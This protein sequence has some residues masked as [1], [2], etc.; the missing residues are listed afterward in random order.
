MRRKFPFWLGLPAV[1]GAC[2]SDSTTP[3]AGP[4]KVTLSITKLWPK[5]SQTWCP[6]GSPESCDAQAPEPVVIGC[7]RLLGVSVD[8]QNFSL[9]VPDACA[10]SPQCG[11]LA[12]T[13]D[14]DAMPIS[15]T[16]AAKTLLLDLSPLEGLGTLEGEH[17]IRP[18]LFLAS[19]R[20]FT[21]PFAAEPVDVGVE[22]E[23][24]DCSGQTGGTGGSGAMGGTG[25]TG[26]TGGSSASGGTGGAAGETQGGAAGET[27]GGA[28]GEAGSGAGGEPAGGMSGSGGSP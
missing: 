3:P 13:V 7:D 16:G 8:V 20:P 24:A 5:D 15:T 4:G 22:F 6:E 21:R 14:P 26:G 12:L 28:S 18:S 1:L 9:R 10:D 11:Y 19:D 2:G 25:G 27:Q 23:L 17:V